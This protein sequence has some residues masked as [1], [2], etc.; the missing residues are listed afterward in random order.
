MEA[1]DTLTVVVG[2]R[3]EQWRLQKDTITPHAS[4]QLTIWS[5]E[6]RS[7]TAEAS[8]VFDCLLELR[9]QIEP[10]GAHICC[11]GS[12]RDAWA[13]GMQRDMGQGLVVYLLDG[14]QPKERPPQVNTLDP[15][16]AT[17][18]VSVEVQLAWH[19]DWLRNRP[20]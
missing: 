2:E 7:W 4:Y 12:R 5:P 8:D 20:A 6:A 9:K 14:V 18:V 11:N 15:A 19:G 16:P 3:T 10:I 13:S 1:P 17:E